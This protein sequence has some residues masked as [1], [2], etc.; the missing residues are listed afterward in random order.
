M[1]RF[2]AS[3]CISTALAIGL[4]SCAHSQLTKQRAVQ[5]AASAALITGMVVLAA[6]ARCGNCNIGVDS[7][8]QAAL[9]PR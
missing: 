2:I 4:T 9:P 5:V 7:P 1:K 3:V 6:N 8:Q